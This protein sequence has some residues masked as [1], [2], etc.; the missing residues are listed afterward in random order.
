LERFL[1]L[2]AGENIQVC[3]PSTP[4]QYF[5]LLRRQI[6][7]PFRKP[8]VVMTP[9][10]LLRHPLAVSRL[11]DLSDGHF[12]AVLDDPET[13]EAPKNV[14]FCSGKIFYQLY[15]RR[16][17]IE[18]ME[19]VIVRLEQ[20]YP[21]PEGQIKKAVEK[22]NG[23][24]KWYWVQEEPENMGGWHFIRSYL[25]DISGRPFVYI[26]RMA[27]SSPASGFHAIYQQQQEAIIEQAI[28]PPAVE[29]DKET[30]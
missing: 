30:K 2:C 6:G 11:D 29:K 10:S 3:N 8:L 4:A 17:D 1:Q 19:T 22:Y 7:A 23:A 27:A 13:T 5:H 24:K 14:I 20:L 16:S 26:G 25:E 15:K 9:K 12:Q 21:V 18:N 28:G